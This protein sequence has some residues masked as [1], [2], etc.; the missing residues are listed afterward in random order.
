MRITMARIAHVSRH[1][2][3]LIAGIISAAPFLDR[4]FPTRL[5]HL[6]GLFLTPLYHLHPCRRASLQAW[7]PACAGKTEG[8]DLRL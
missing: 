6:G 4:L 5:Y 1:L 2:D 7:I 8:K 3:S